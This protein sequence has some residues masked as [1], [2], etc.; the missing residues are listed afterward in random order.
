MKQS[1]LLEE[2]YLISGDYNNRDLRVE[3][4]LSSISSIISL[5]FPSWKWRAAHHFLE[6]SKIAMLCFTRM[7]KIDGFLWS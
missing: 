6:D 7:K 5:V 4:F 2:D 1:A 3:I